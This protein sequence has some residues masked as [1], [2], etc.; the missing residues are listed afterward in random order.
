MPT[1][2]TQISPSQFY[3]PEMTDLVSLIEL[4]SKET[5]TISKI[6]SISVSNSSSFQKFELVVENTEGE[7]VKIVAVQDKDDKSVEVLSVETVEEQ[8]KV[9]E[10]VQTINKKTVNEYGV[11]V[12]FTN[13]VTTI[14]SDQNCNIALNFINSQLTQYQN[15]EVVSSYSK[16]YTQT[17]SHTLI[18]SDGSKQI[19]VTGNIDLKSLRYIP[20]EHK[21]VP[22]SILYPSINQ[23]TIPSAIYPSY[24]KDHKEVKD[25]ETI[26]VEKYKIFKGKTPSSTVIEAFT[27]VIKTTFNYDIGAKKFV[28]VVDYNTL[29][30]TA[31]IL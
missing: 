5:V 6:K 4:N 1:P 7:E 27:D 21:E 3:K 20:V 30:S 8:V 15:Y 25:S 10:N 22:V 18:L 19:Q 24:V 26:L 14:K 17:Q 23:H 16:T 13:D 11:S 12:E 29:T 9:V 31:K 2:I 28:A